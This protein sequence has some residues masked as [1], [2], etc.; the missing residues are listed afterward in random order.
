MNLIA[1]V[2]DAIE[3]KQ[4][5]QNSLDIGTIMISCDRIDDVVKMKFKDN[6]CGMSEDT[7]SK[8]FEP[9]FTTKDV[10]KGTGLGLSISYGTI[11]KHNGN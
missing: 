6:G 1:N 10:G 9:F 3:E 2:C 4:R 11:Q 5:Q 8:L 7:I